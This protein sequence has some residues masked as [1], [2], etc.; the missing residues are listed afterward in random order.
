M[1]F[2]SYLAWLF[3]TLFGINSEKD[4]KKSN[5]KLSSIQLYIVLTLYL[6]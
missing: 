5:K 2:L 4:N 6:S 1:L 3:S